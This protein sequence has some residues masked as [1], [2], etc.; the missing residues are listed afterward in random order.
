[1]WTKN[2]YLMN[3]LNSNYLDGRFSFG[4]QKFHLNSCTL[5]T[6]SFLWPSRFP[7]FFYK[8]A[9]W[10]DK[11]KLVMAGFCFCEETIIGFGW[12]STSQRTIRLGEW[13]QGSIRG[14]TNINTCTLIYY[15]I[16]FSLCIHRYECIKFFYVI[17][18]ECRSCSSY[19]VKSLCSELIT[20]RCDE[21]FSLY[22]YHCAW[23]K[24]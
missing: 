1:M 9:L 18:K 5:L 13:L 22:Q 24:F 2:A 15:I 17:F 4:G 3:K 19:H 21:G 16:L 12:W 20:A 14:T 10:V 23:G 8:N 7:Y 11:G 6:K